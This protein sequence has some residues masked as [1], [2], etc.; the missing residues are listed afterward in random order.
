MSYVSP[1]EGLRISD[2]RSV[3]QFSS[4]TRC[5][6]S[7][8]LE[9]VERKPAKPAA[10]LAQGSAV[11]KAVEQWE[12]SLR[13]ISWERLSQLYLAEYNGLIAEGLAVEPNPDRWLTGGR[14]KGSDDI[15][16][17]RERGLEQLQ[18]YITYAINAAERPLMVDDETPVIEHEF[19]LDLDGVEVIGFIDMVVEWPNG[20]VAVRDLKTGTKRPDWAIQLG[21]YKVAL[22]A[23][24]GIDV[25]WGDFYMA[26]DNRPLPPVS[27]K[28]F[29]RQYVTDMFHTLDRSIRDGLWLP[30]PGDQCRVCGVSDYCTA[31]GALQ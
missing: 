31:M 30:N 7:Y 26:K 9:R 8:R 12:L 27:L 10:W 1:S 22:E 13:T 19:R 16:R 15:K 4:F 24:F 11:H 28:R 14:V 29:T 6:E 18:G 2:H 17:R 23:E 3:S 20:V 25:A 21:I 5:G